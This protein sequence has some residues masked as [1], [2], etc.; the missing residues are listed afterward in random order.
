MARALDR[1]IF[2]CRDSHAALAIP[3]K[4]RSQSLRG[5]KDFNAWIFMSSQCLIVVI[6]LHTLKGIS[7]LDEY[8]LDGRKIPDQ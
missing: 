2:R 6:N 1:E 5:K 3:I 8:T 7:L 4:I